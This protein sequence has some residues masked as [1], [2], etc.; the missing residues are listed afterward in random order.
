MEP[1]LREAGWKTVVVEPVA[2][3]AVQATSRADL[4]IA[5]ALED[6]ALPDSCVPTIGMFDVLEH[7]DDPVAA[8]R[9]CARVLRPGGVVVVTV[10]SHQWLWSEIDKVAGHKIRYSPQTLRQQGECAGLDL[11]EARRFFV[12]LVPGAAL[13]RLTRRGVADAG[14]V[15]AKEEEMLNPPPAQARLLKLLVA[16]DHLARGRMRSPIGLSLLGVLKKPG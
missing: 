6:I 12:A 5:A 16:T 13:M 14:D 8:L 7:L 1:A 11:V 3:A 4:V 10:P 2:R 9:E 15:L